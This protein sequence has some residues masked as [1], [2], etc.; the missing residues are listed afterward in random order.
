MTDVEAAALQSHPLY[1]PT[2]A[3]KEKLPQLEQK[4]DVGILAADQ[5]YRAIKSAILNLQYP[6]GSL[7]KDTRL[8][9]TLQ[10]GR[11]PI[12]E[13]L[14]KLEVELLVVSRPRQGTYV[15]EI[16]VSDFAQQHPVHRQLTALAVDL[17]VQRLTPR[18]IDV[19]RTLQQ[20]LI[21][22]ETVDMIS[23]IHAVL[24]FHHQMARSSRNLYLSQML[25]RYC[26]YI[27]RIW[28]IA[29]P[30]MRSSDLFLDDYAELVQL[31]GERDESRAP[32]LMADHLDAVHQRILGY[33]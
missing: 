29:A 27:Q 28:L 3:V 6:P 19:L 24:R 4:G 11:T 16:S 25:E 2:P 15:S 7:I 20:Q 14:K 26:G 21:T 32:Q 1:L 9:K 18:R 12:R 17:A 10:L 30:G 13:A 23:L 22:G 5:A 31:M 33:F 8:M